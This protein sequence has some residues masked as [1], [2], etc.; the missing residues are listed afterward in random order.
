M[1]FFLP[2]AVGRSALSIPLFLR[3]QPLRPGIEK[4]RFPWRVCAFFRVPLTLAPWSTSPMAAEGSFLPTL[5]FSAVAQGPESPGNATWEVSWKR[6]L[7]FLETFSL[8]LC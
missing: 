3:S 1:L 7:R 4:A 5:L 8:K 2:L 6:K